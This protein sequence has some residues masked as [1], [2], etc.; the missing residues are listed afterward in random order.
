MSRS[1]RVAVLGPKGQCGSCVVDELLSRGHRVVGISRAPPKTWAKPGEY[2]G[3][4]CDFSD[5]KGLSKILTD[6]DFDAVV[7]AFAPP[8]VDMKS[9]Y[10]VGVE[11]HGNIKM[12][13]L[14]SAFRGPLIIIGKLT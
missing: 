12:A 1:L 3:I 8:L 11:G 10:L 13:I 7:C 4:P 14:R 5:I 6:G 9:A 2:G